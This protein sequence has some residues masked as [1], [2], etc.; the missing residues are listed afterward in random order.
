[1]L[2]AYRISPQPPK[3]DTKSVTHYIRVRPYRTSV[4]MER[5]RSLSKVRGSTRDHRALLHLGFR[6]LNRITGYQ[7][8]NDLGLQRAPTQLERLQRQ[9][10]GDYVLPPV[11]VA[12]DGPLG[13]E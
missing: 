6:G 4:I 13:G 3:Y 8:L 11:K 5:A 9:R 7:A 2:E 12:V 1:M 10:K